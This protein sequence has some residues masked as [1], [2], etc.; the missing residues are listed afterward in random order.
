MAAVASADR[1]VEETSVAAAEASAYVSI[2]TAGLVLAGVHHFP[3]DRHLRNEGRR[4][5]PLAIPPVAVHKA[6]AVMVRA[7]DRTL[8]FSP[9]KEKSVLKKVPT[10]A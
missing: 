9:G 7:S 10:M 1:L 8:I 5:P 2:S 6:A 4:L 3:G